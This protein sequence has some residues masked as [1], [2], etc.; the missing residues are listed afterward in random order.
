MQTRLKKLEDIWTKLSLTKIDQS[1][2]MPNFVE[3][4]INKI[5]RTSKL[6]LELRSFGTEIVN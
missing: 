2:I 6:L 5:V 4:R 3:N 1:E